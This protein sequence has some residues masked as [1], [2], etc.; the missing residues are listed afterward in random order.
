MAWP[1]ALAPRGPPARAGRFGSPPGTESREAG[2]IDASRAAS[3]RRLEAVVDD[4]AAHDVQAVAGGA[5][6]GLVPQLQ[7]DAVGDGEDALVGGL[8]GRGA[9]GDVGVV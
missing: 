8:E 7:L 1:T 4:A 2:R 3:I 6:E 5:G 9:V